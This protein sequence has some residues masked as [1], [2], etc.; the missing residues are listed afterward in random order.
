MKAWMS[1]CMAALVVAA[2]LA[3][4]SNQQEARLNDDAA[5]EKSLGSSAER[6]QTAQV[7]GAAQRINLDAV[8]QAFW[9]TQGRDMSAAMAAFEKRVNEIFE[10][11]EVVSIDAARNDNTLTVVGYI[12]KNQQAGFQKGDDRLFAIEQTGQVANGQ[13]PYRVSDGAGVPYYAGS[14]S[15]GV[16]SFMM[17]M[18]LGS[19]MN[20]W[21]GHYHTPYASH[22][23]LQS[24]RDSYRST[25]GYQNQ[26][27]SNQ[28][29]S[30]RFK[31][32]STGEGYQSQRGFGQSASQTS[33]KRRE[34][35]GTGGTTGGAWGSRRS[36]GSGFGSSERS[37]DSWSSRRRSDGGSVGSSERSSGSWFGRRSSSGSSSGSW[38]GRRS[39]GG[40]GGRR[41]R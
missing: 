7:A 11:K 26:V 23:S 22:R 34:W 28:S 12:D 18:M 19:M 15:S 14:H 40:F 5:L 4:C 30:S 2:N 37:S 29:F 6:Y 10:G 35:G 27:K 9:Q 36:D 3:G 38:G 8:R 32:R 17:G 21:G 25:P 20:N 33:S 16:G 31:L 41:R 13:V 1:V 24:W 39:F